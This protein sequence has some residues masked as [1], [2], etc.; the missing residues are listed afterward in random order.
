MSNEMMVEKGSGNWGN[1]D[2][3][4]S[5]NINGLNVVFQIGDSITQII[6]HDLIILNNTVDLELLDTVT[7][8]NELRTTPEETIHGN[9]SDSSS[10]FFHVGFIIPRLNF[11]SDSGLSNGLGLVGLL[12]VI[13]SN[14]LS[15]DLLGFLINFLV[16][17]TEEID[18]I[19]IF[20]SSGSSSGGSSG[21]PI[22]SSC[23]YKHVP[24][25]LQSNAR[26]SCV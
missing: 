16:I 10:Q 18:I 21:F 8:G 26:V 6:H 3:L 17:G 2:L 4:H 19:L 20:L 5:S 25:H 1:L 9:S 23:Q 13:F 12:G 24:E 11:K 22:V 15:L 7:N 14:T